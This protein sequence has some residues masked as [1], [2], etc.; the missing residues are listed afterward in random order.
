M[1][2]WA[3]QLWRL[4]C[5]R[6]GADVI[7]DIANH[8]RSEYPRECCGLVVVI[9]GRERYWPCRNMAETPLENFILHPEDYAA[10]E[11]AGEV[12]AVVHSHPDATAA[13]SEADRRM[14]GEGGIRWWIVSVDAT[15]RVSE[16]Y[17]MEPVKYVPPLVGRKF[18]HGINDCYSLVRD[19]YSTKLGITLPD[20]E[21]RDMWWDK[22]D[23]LYM[24][25]FQDAGFRIV[26]GEPQQHDVILMQVRAPVVNHAGV[27]LGDMQV[28]HHFYD[29]LSSRDLYGG[30]LQDVTRHLIRHRE[31]G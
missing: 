11:D 29:R 20:F 19:Y 25:H 2:G 28:M 31:V 10:A 22:G 13:P 1:A 17:I 14:C 8:A 16:P 21:R 12:V 6:P 4:C 7:D 15:G 23:D 30:Y 26:G 18:V 24:Q 3:T 5:R 9:K 27:Y